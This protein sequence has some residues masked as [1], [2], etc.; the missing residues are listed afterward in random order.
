[1]QIKTVSSNS[2]TLENQYQTVNALRTD[3][4]MRIPFNRISNGSL[5]IAWFRMDDELK[6][7]NI[8]LEQSTIYDNVPCRR[9]FNIR[10]IYTS[11]RF[12]CCPLFFSIFIVKHL[13]GCWHW[14][15]NWKVNCI[16]FK[17]KL[18]KCIHGNRNQIFTNS[19]SINESSQFECMHAVVMNISWQNQSI[20]EI[21]DFN[22]Y[23]NE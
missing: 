6:P 15:V 4:K 23:W 1:M 12:Q 8:P 20:C 7:H 16:Q 18:M 5:S 14:F 21:E 10:Q 2:L 3:Q 9:L 11:I 22:L 19:N 17:L 13:R